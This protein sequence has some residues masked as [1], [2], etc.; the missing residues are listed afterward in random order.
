MILRKMQ[1]ELQEKLDNLVSEIYEA[2]GESFN[3]LN[4]QGHCFI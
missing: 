2:A 3:N 1:N 4:H